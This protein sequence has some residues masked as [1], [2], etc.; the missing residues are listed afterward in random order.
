MARVTTW[1]WSR[2][3]TEKRR[4]PKSGMDFRFDR[5]LYARFEDENTERTVRMAKGCPC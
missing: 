3:D 5:R 2:V 1:Y 4:D